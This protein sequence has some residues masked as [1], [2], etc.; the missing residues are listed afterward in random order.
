MCCTLTCCSLV[1]KQSVPLYILHGDPADNVWLVKLQN[2]LL[3]LI[4]AIWS[5]RLIYS[6]LYRLHHGRYS[7]HRCM[8]SR[9]LLE[10]QLDTRQIRLDMC[11]PADNLRLPPP[12]LPW[13]RQRQLEQTHTC[14]RYSK[15]WLRHCGER[16]ACNC[17]YESG[18][19]RA[20]PK[21]I[22]RPPMDTNAT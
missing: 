9:L 10:A 14:L 17:W 16:N 19:Y 15:H 5:K 21:N 6:H 18:L 2:Y 22:R 12:S 3:S 7:C 20:R 13:D 8:E 11:C 1:Q 4:E